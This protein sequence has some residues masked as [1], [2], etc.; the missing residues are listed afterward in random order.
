MGTQLQT[1]IL[2][3]TTKSASD[4]DSAPCALF[5]GIL[6]PVGRFA[7]IR[8]AWGSNIP[9]SAST[10]SAPSWHP[11]QCRRPGRS[12]VQRAFRPRPLLTSGGRHS[13]VDGRP[14]RAC[15]LQQLVTRSDFACEGA[16]IW[17]YRKS[18]K[19]KDIYRRFISRKSC[20]RI[21]IEIIFTPGNTA[22]W[23]SWVSVMNR[24]PFHAFYHSL[25]PEEGR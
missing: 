19:T 8:N 12:P 15:E 16:F 20:W 13:C 3:A 11:R 23:K 6:E 7:T 4:E 22:F 24:P 17:R 5:S 10:D 9:S 2:S 25:T 14:K 21:L 18:D 1:L